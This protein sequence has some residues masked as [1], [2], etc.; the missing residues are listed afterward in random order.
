MTLRS[1]LQLRPH[2]IGLDMC[3]D[4]E[5][6]KFETF[7]VTIKPGEVLT[8]QLFDLLG[9]YSFDL[10]IFPNGTDEKHRGVVEVRLIRSDELE[11]VVR[12]RFSFEALTID[13]QSYY[14]RVS[15]HESTHPFSQKGDFTGTEIG[16]LVDLRRHGLL[17][18]DALRLRV[19]FSPEFP[20]V[21]RPRTTCQ[22]IQAASYAR[23]LGGLLESAMFSDI[24]VIAGGREFPAHRNIL[25]ARSPVFQRLL[26][27]NMSEASTGKIE[28]SDVDARTMADFMLFI[29]TGS[30]NGGSND[31]AEQGLEEIGEANNVMGRWFFL[32]AEDG[33]FE[34]HRDQYGTLGF[35]GSVGEWSRVNPEHR[36]LEGL[37]HDV[38]PQGWQMTLPNGSIVSL[39][40]VDGGMEV[41]HKIN[42]ESS[43]TSSAHS[44]QT[45]EEK[46]RVTEGWCNLLCAA[47]KYGV[48]KLVALCEERLVA[49]LHF[50]TAAAML[51][52]ANQTARESFRSTILSYIT[53]DEATLHA[54]KDTREF[55]T[56]DRE[57][58]L[59]VMEFFLRPT[60]KRQR[61]EARDKEFID[62]EEWSRLS[63]AQLRR[64]C[65]ERGLGTGGTRER[66]MELL[67]A[68]T[69]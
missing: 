32:D 58:A 23:E 10:E 7:A 30:C 8:K 37:L 18:G 38:S 16:Q 17:A 43:W 11:G 14:G 60:R 59:E 62:D 53:Q 3:V 40:L 1:A 68:N 61:S 64:A 39:S 36:H 35:K 44:I 22:D 24:I 47:E 9:C 42:D 41:E 2:G 12:G 4:F 34:V 63:N 52:V 50:S 56:L 66:L 13:W 15:R 31:Q 67:R 19:R 21:Q 33:S 49:M 29:Y 65:A 26:S 69:L 48:S 27:T 55:D 57:L 5:L 25:A 54:V 28:V 51:R 46:G 45:L 6:Q 20:E